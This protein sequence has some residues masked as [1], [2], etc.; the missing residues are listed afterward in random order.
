MRRNA[1][2]LLTLSTLAAAAPF[3][4]ACNT[5]RGAGEDLSAAGNR[6]EQSAERNNTYSHPP[7]YR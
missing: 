1:R 4:T 6:I 7:A 5:T 3:I 2:L